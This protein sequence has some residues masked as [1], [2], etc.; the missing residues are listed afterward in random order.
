MYLEAWDSSVLLAG[1]GFSASD[2]SAV[3]S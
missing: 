3:C 2:K 1:L